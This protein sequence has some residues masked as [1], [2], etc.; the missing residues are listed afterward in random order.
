MA[1][2]GLKPST[3][4][5][6]VKA[7]LREIQHFY[8]EG[9]RGAVAKEKKDN[10]A[11]KKKRRVSAVEEEVVNAIRSLPHLYERVLVFE[12][13]QLREVFDH[14]APLVPD[15]TIHSLRQVLDAQGIHFA[16][17]WG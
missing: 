9:P 1:C 5:G 2:F 17:P 16:R 7:R 11:P 10:R 12:P 8:R 14:V 13:V 3:S 15:L 4:L 6:F